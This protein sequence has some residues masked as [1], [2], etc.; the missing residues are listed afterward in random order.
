MNCIFVSDLHGKIERYESLF[1]LISSEKPSIVFLG[2]DLLP[3]EHLSRQAIDIQH[4]DFIHSYLLKR[5][6]QLRDQLQH[7]YPRIFVILGND[8]AR[9]R[10]ASILELAGEGLWYYLHF[11]KI[12]LEPYSLYGYSFIPPS[13]FQLKDWEKYDI[14]RFVDPGCISP[15][16]GFRTMY[17]SNDEKKYSTIREDL[18]KLAADDNLD[19]SIFLFHSPPYQTQ[20]DRAALDGQMIDNVPLDINIGSIAIRRFI[21]QRQPL[22][23]LHGHVHESVRITGSWREQLGRT[24]MFS[25]AHAGRELAVIRFDPAIPQKASREIIS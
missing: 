9:I 19:H 5:M 4:K 14:S 23:T 18:E 20:L 8:D 17:V 1:R 12:R 25:A 16:E 3:H 10:E 22:I 2:G 24:F 11:R 7:N 6:V 21:E 13:P 15:E